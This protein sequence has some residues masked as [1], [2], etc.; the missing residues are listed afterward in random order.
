L[1]SWPPKMLIDRRRGDQD[2]ARIMGH[3]LRMRDDLL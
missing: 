2:Y 3:D 1:I